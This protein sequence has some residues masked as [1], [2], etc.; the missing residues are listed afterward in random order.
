MDTSMMVTPDIAS[1][2]TAQASVRTQTDVGTAMLSESLD[3]MKSQGAAMTRMMELSVN[4]SVGG[5][6]DMSV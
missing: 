3:T 5:N 2:A 4:P 6:F 1:L